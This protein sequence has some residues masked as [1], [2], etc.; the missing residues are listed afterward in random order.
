MSSYGAWSVKGIDDRARA[1]AKEQA[2]LKGVTLGDYI[3]DL[4]LQG[5]QRSEAEPVAEAAPEPVDPVSFAQTPPAA[6]PAR[7]ATLPIDTLARRIEAAEARSTLAI[8]GIDQSV[9]G[10]LARI[11]SSENNASAM[12]AEVEGMIDELRETHETLQSKVRELEH[13]DTAQKNLQTMKTLEQALAQLASHVH[14]ENNLTQE[15]TAAIKGRVES[16][17]SDFSD[18]VEQIEGRIESRL[19]DATDRVHKVVEQAELRAEGTSRHLS[20]RFSAVEASVAARLAK[21]DDIASRMGT[22]EADFVGKVNALEDNIEISNRGQVEVSS[23]LTKVEEDVAD[24]FEEIEKV[25]STEG[26][27]DP[28]VESRITQIEDEVIGAVDALERGLETSQRTGEDISARVGVIEQDVSGAITTMEDTLLRI[29]ERLNRAETTTDSALK[30][31]EETFA[32]LDQR[33]EGVAANANPEVAEGLRESFES[34]FEDLATELRAT[35][36][37]LS[38]LSRVPPAP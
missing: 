9:L 10:L 19:S 37:V 31:L 3:N 18:R 14:E 36:S 16:G 8:T 25:R 15:E 2:R 28:Q 5:G 29:Q 22:L 12:T 24:A 7:E 23:R 26:V 34:K 11:E 4:L 21:V 6:P 1:A 35:L 17:F 33:I 30:A 32:T 27:I 20:E 13:D 38:R